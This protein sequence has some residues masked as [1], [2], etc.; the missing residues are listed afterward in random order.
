MGIFDFL[1]GSKKKEQERF[2]LEEEACRQKLEQER[3]ARE[4]E[5][6]LE[7]NRRKEQERQARLKAEREQ[8]ESVQPFTF[9]SNCHQRY[10]NDAPVQGLQK[11]LRT[12]SLVKNTNGCPGYRLQPGIG[13]IV[14]IYNDDLGKPNMSDKPM[15]VVHKTDTS[16]ELRGFPIEAQ[17]PF[18]WQEV[19]Y[20]DYGFIVYYKN[21]QIDKC[22]LHMYDRNVRIEYCKKE[23]SSQKNPKVETV[24]VPPKKE[25][26]TEITETEIFVQEAL[27]QLSIGNDG[28]ATYHPLFKAWRSFQRDP[29]QLKHIKDWGNFGMGLMIFLSYGT[30]SDIDDKQQLA[31]VAY[32]F[33]SKAIKK[34]PQNINLYKNRLILMIS[35]HEA[36]E[37]TVSSVVNKDAGFMFMNL[38]PFKARDAMFK[39]EF[40]DLLRGPQLLSVDMLAQR[41]MDLQNKISN[42]FFGPDQDNAKVRDRGNELH[43]EIL[44]YLENKVIEDGDLDF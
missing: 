19:D 7:E 29:E 10:E 14:K 30:V 4:R 5:R 40:A 39:M 28:D 9:K 23:F 33:L 31:S 34:S 3:I 36:F 44:E 24:T 35:N 41:Y 6:R 16:V 11:C 38:S 42:G 18:G 17:S 43:Q 26:S 1:F 25:K 27:Q 2:R 21:G 8:A 20:S 12:V 13:Y 32:L 15:K 22:I 37:Y